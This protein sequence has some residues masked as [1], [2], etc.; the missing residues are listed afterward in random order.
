MAGQATKPSADALKE[1]G[2]ALFAKKDYEA[3]IRKYTE[4]LK[5][6][7]NN[8]VLH[9]NRSACSF[10]RKRYQDAMTDARRATEIDPSYSKEWSRA[11]AAHAALGD[12]HASA[13]CW[14]KALDALPTANL[15]AA[16]QSQKDLYEAK[17]RIMQKNL[18]KPVES[19]QPKTATALPS[20]TDAPSWVRAKTMIS[21]MLASGTQ[22]SA[23]VIADCEW[24]NDLPINE[25]IE[26][27]SY[28]AWVAAGPEY[29]K[30]EA[31]KLL[32]SQGWDVTR[33]ALAITVRSWIL[34]GIVAGCFHDSQGTGIEFLDRALE[35][36]RWG[37]EEWTDVPKDTRGAIFDLSYVLGV[38]SLYLILWLMACK[39][40][41][42]MFPE[43][44]LL[45]KAE[46]LIKESDDVPY[47]N[48]TNSIGFDLT[49]RRYPRGRAYC[50]IG[51]YHD[52]ASEIDP[53][54]GKSEASILEHHL[55]A[56]E[57]Y[58]QAANEYA[59]DDIY[60]LWYMNAGLQ[61]FWRCGAP[62]CVTMPMMKMVREHLPNVKKIWEHDQMTKTG[63]TGFELTMK[64]E[65]QY[66]EGLDN[67]TLTIDQA[68]IPDEYVLDEIAVPEW[69]ED[70]VAS[71]MKLL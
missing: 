51:W 45:E 20:F 24:A 15:S 64:M 63:R 10:N 25:M 16:E 36:L 6:D 53:E 39:K 23:F 55:R 3:A 54:G 70:M 69:T 43:E 13:M 5:L 71:I 21:E 49:Y 44:T 68:P 31:L 48:E 28:K 34:K 12:E 8:A 2:N 27:R 58:L 26:T 56:G 35:I 30:V 47:D 67:G 61:Q 66:R 17:L 11:A 59:I 32:E 19:A 65:K 57:A 18:R 50:M 29:V 52:V 7:E 1:E 62:L 22:S 60:H 42:D 37:Q 38:K 4:A 14:K 9:A 46:A 40:D 41:S 33:P